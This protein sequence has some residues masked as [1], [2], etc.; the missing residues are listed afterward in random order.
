MSVAPILPDFTEDLNGCKLSFNGNEMLKSINQPL[1]YTAEQISEIIKCKNDIN[2]FAENYY[3]IL[4][5]DEGMVKI[6]LRDYQ[7]DLIK[8]FNDHRFNI[9]LASR[10]IGKSTSFEIF[11]MHYIL[12][13][14]DKRVAILANKAANSFDILRKIKNAYELLPKWL[15]Q[16]VK[17]WN[18]G[19]I[20]LENGC[21]VIAA[22]TSSSS[23]RSK[24]INVLIIDEHA[25]VPQGVWEDFYA[26]S[27]PTISSSKTSKVIFVS[28]PNGM[29]HFYKFWTDASAGKNKF[30]PYRVDW[31]Q[32]PGRDE[33]WK[34]ETI[35]NVGLQTF[36]QEYGNNFLGSA[37]TLVEG[38][39]IAQMRFK[40]PL[41]WTPLHEDLPADLHDKMKIFELPQKGRTYSLGVDPSKIT[42]ESIGDAFGLQVLD[43]TDLPYRQVATFYA[44]NGFNYLQGPEVIMKYGSFY[45]EAITFIENNS[46]GQEIA[47][48]TAFDYEYEGTFF[49]KG[50][51]PGFNTN[52]KTKR[53]GCTNLKILCEN[54]KLELNDF[55][56]ISQMSTF[57]KKRDS[58][59]AEATYKD[60]LIMSLIAS[61]FFMQRS[62]FQDEDDKREFIKKL[63]D[64][65][66]AQRAVEMKDDD[67]PSFGIV[68]D[69]D[70]FDGGDISIPWTP[71]DSDW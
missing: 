12:F 51:T 28:T 6:G 31:W 5:L 24:S 39:I 32:V 2:Y 4:S 17:T 9:V 55:D 46:I 11:V 54:Y 29:N 18:Q 67:M 42:A 58:Y 70:G 35:A 20:E 62:E 50:N 19:R 21:S 36:N 64:G 37:G 8:N 1:A 16:G 56:T 14:S 15:Q 30:V 3:Y 34:E 26:S 66:A 7:K 71:P 69:A 68:P 48:L 45:N 65:Q 63:F 23:I 57:I 13:N 52:K 44:K 33:K 22:A 38:H 53:L 27:Y 60:D 59:A 49:E 47:N 41:E 25:F 43:I 40:D 61:L 10:Q